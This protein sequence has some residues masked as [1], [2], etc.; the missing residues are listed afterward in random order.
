MGAYLIHLGPE[1]VVWWGLGKAVRV[2]FLYKTVMCVFL[3]S[4]DRQLVNGPYP[5][6]NQ[7]SL[8]A[9]SLIDL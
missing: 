7:L 3:Y 5:E 2:M 6:V 8:L 1:D 4:A 9:S